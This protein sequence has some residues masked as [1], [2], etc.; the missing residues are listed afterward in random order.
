MD[1]TTKQK[2]YNPNN[3]SALARYLGVSTATIHNWSKG[4]HKEIKQGHEPTIRK[5]NLIMLGWQK[6]CEDVANGK[7]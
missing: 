6:T 7:A 5:F 1:K 3:K 2:V 4:R